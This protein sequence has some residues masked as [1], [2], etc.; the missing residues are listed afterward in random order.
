MYK[1]THVELIYIYICI[2]ILS[3]YPLLFNSIVFIPQETSDP[4]FS[5]PTPC[6]PC[7]AWLR[8]REG[9]PEFPR[10]WASHLGIRRDLGSGVLESRDKDGCIPNVRVLPWYENV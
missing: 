7:S 8:L 10:V 9:W 6:S 5:S 3:D 2:H 1:Y 4:L